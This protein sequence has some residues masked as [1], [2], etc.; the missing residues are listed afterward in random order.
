MDAKDK[1][2]LYHLDMD[3]SQSL[4]RLAKN[5]GVRKE[6]VRYRFNNLVESGV[7]KNTYVA[8]NL[9][10]MGYTYYK[11]YIKLHKMD[12]SK[13]KEFISFV[14][15]IDQVTWSA[16]LEGSYDIAFTVLATSVHEFD[17]I[18]KKINNKYGEYFRNHEIV[19]LTSSHEFSLDFLVGSSPN[20]SYDSYL[21]GGIHP[22]YKLSDKEKK[23]IECLNKRPRISIKNVAEDSGY[24]PMVVRYIIKKLKRAGMIRRLSI[25]IDSSCMDETY[26][27]F[28]VP[29]KFTGFT[30]DEEKKFFRYIKSQPYFTIYSTCIGKWD[31]EL[32]IWTKNN[33]HY[34]EIMRDLINKF[35]HIIQEYDTLFVSEQ[36]KV[37]Y[38]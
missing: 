4:S 23:I 33:K 9:S 22:L 17:S 12:S 35:S 36:H 32:N 34:R 1:K 7:L 10:R 29:I 16:S 14:S 26:Y 20:L 6:V 2:I 27:K 8:M 13:E 25:L 30:S 28:R 19:I 18:W 38:T 11:I 21:F 5:I 15:D 24:S 37:N 3:S 31:V